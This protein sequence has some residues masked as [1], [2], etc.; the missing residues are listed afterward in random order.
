MYSRSHSP[1]TNLAAQITLVSI[2]GATCPDY[3]RWVLFT[4]QIVTLLLSFCSFTK[5]SNFST[6]DMGVLHACTTPQGMKP[7]G[8][9]GPGG[10][11]CPIKCKSTWSTFTP[12]KRQISFLFGMLSS[13]GGF[14][15]S[16]LAPIWAALTLNP[17]SQHCTQVSH[18]HIPHQIFSS[19]RFSTVSGHVMLDTI[20]YG[21]HCTW[22]CASWPH[23]TPLS[24]F[25]PSGGKINV[26]SWTKGSGIK[27]SWRRTWTTTSSR[28]LRSSPMR[29]KSPT[30]R[31]CGIHSCCCR[32]NL[33]NLSSN[34][35]LFWNVTSVKLLCGGWNLIRRQAKLAAR[36]EERD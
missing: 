18:L 7:C 19:T 23:K 1:V 30:F 13:P 27:R 20:T 3:R 4:C 32:E 14:L 2:S 5:L 33:H 22:G 29:E 8:N 26:T 35:D 17:C 34:G 25:R 36:R 28:T 21:K 15:L 24:H 9:D 10:Q 31:T 16:T 6:P 12:W 11:D